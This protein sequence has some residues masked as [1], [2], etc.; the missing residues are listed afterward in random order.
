MFHF[1]DVSG[2]KH[3]RKYWISYFDNVS[4]ILFIVDISCYDQTM[5]EDCHTNRM[6]D[7][8][9]VFEHI[10]NHPLLK[11]PDIII[12][13]NKMDKFK[14]KVKEIGIQRHF[15]DYNG[16]LPRLTSRKALVRLRWLSVLLQQIR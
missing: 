2:L 8:L 15:P 9:T 14:K 4:S 13:F 11:L 1:Y 12:F 3:H 16:I 6:Q 10:A 7:T 5:A